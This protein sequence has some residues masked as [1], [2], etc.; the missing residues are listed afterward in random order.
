M[1]CHYHRDKQTGERFLIPECWGT[2]MH[3]HL[4]DKE[5]LS[6]CHC[7]KNQ[8]TQA[9][10]IEELRVDLRRLRDEFDKYKENN[11]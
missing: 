5:A 8:K 7:S 10:L 2:V 11:K 9:E 1:K 4:S 3:M 6:F